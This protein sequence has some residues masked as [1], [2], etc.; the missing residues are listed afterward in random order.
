[1]FERIDQFAVNKLGV[2]CAQGDYVA[3]SLVGVDQ[4]AN[5]AVMVVRVNVVEA[6]V[7]V[8]TLVA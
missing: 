1:M 2:R 8:V 4:P 3:A 6:A 5:T 7:V